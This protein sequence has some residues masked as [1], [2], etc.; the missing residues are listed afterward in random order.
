MIYAY[1]RLVRQLPPARV[2]GPP[3]PGPRH[4]VTS[5]QGRTAFGERRGQL[6]CRPGRGSERVVRAQTTKSLCH[7]LDG[8]SLHA[9]TRVAADR[10]IRAGSQSAPSA[11]LELHFPASF[12]DR[13]PGRPC[14]RR[15]RGLEPVRT[16]VT[17]GALTAGD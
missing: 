7:D 12:V 4:E 6:D 3:P 1:G 14:L 16:P 5:A 8:F 2:E 15:T 11:L 17:A 9:A 13:E 10:P